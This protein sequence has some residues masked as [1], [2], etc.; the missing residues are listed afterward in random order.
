MFELFKT[1]S[2][3]ISPVMASD[4]LPITSDNDAILGTFRWESFFSACTRMKDR[5][6]WAQL[7]KGWKKKRL[8]DP[9]IPEG[10][11][12]LPKKVWTGVVL[13]G[14]NPFSEGTWTIKV[15]QYWPSLIFMTKQ[16]YSLFSQDDPGIHH[17]PYLHDELLVL[18]TV[19]SAI[20]CRKQKKGFSALV[21]EV[22]SGMWG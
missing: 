11:S 9:S 21:V 19:K 6:K 13:V 3:N 8:I 7:C 2:P 4:F 20:W 10:P 17:P 12:T 18:W 5:I 1:S 15:C 16:T 22:F 14:P